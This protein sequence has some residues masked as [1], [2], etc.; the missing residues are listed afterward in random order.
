MR[1]PRLIETWGRRT[2]AERPW[3]AARLVYLWAMGKAAGP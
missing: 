1:N 3:L 2:L